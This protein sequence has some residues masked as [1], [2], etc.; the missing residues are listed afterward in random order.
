MP[1]FEMMFIITDGIYPINS[2]ILFAVFR[3][4]AEGY[5]IFSE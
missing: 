3:I 4:C 5:F 1:S 2:I